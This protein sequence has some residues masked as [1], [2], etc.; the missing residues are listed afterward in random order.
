MAGFTRWILR[1][2]LIVAVFWVLVTAVGIVTV[3][4]ATAA[5]SQT[6]TLPG[7]ESYQADQAIMR[8]YGFNSGNAPIVPAVTL[9]QGTTVDSP[10][11]VQQLNGALAK[12][13]AAAPGAR[14]VS[15]ASTHDRAFV[16]QD[17]RTTFALVYPPLRPG[18]GGFAADPALA[19]TQSALKDV[20]I[21]GAP[22]HVTG[23]DALASG[24]GGSGGPSLF[25]ET[26]IGALGAL[27]ILAFVFGSFLALVPLFM[28]VSAIM[29]T[30]LLVWGSQ[31]SPT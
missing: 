4:R 8:T 9:P 28:A 18:A 21:A 29:A 15:Y 16:S 19:A 2:K 24:G 22:V 30:F 25:V 14:I 11:I 10:G 7:E 27:V 26:L 6:F 17:G 12:V 3:S 20:S 5:L 1:H 13:A 23:I 31:R